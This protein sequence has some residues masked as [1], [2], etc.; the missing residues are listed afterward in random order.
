MQIAGPNLI[1]PP[2]YESSEQPP[3]GFAYMVAWDGTVMRAV[4]GSPILVVV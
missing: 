1:L 2:T 3:V 4:D